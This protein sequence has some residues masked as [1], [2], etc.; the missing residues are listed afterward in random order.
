MICSSFRLDKPTARRRGLRLASAALL[1]LIPASSGLGPARA[2]WTNK[3]GTFEAYWNHSGTVRILDYI[4]ETVAAAGSL[5]GNVIIQTNT[6]G[7]P[8][9]DTECV[10]FAD[11]RTGGLGRCIWT[12]ATGDRVFVELKSPGPAGFG[13]VRGTFIGGDGRYEGIKGGFNFEWNYSV[14]GRGDTTLDG[15]TIRLAGRY[16]IP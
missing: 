6:G 5:T 8:G 11:D 2:D 1:V 13:A 15:Y 14:S 12:G 4:D 3:S 16:E 9:F 7:F 10:V